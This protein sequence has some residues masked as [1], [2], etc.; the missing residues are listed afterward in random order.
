VF[1]LCNPW[2]DGPSWLHMRIVSP[3]RFTDLYTRY[4]GLSELGLGRLL[5]LA[6]A[7]PTGYVVLGWCG[8]LLRPV[9]A[10]FAALGRRSLGAFVLH[11]YGMLLLAQVPHGG[12]LVINT[13]LQLLTVGLIA[14]MLGGVP[15][16]RAVP[17]AT[18]P[19][20]P[21]EALAA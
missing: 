15:R 8:A 19:A 5:N 3:D 20:P 11:V 2:T 14:A 4:F 16:R 7:L 12:G 1:A 6:V 21:R 17:A 10:L 9:Q 18:A 13:M